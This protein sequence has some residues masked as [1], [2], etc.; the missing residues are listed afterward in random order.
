MRRT[1][2]LA[3]PMLVALGLSSVGADSAHAGNK[4]YNQRPFLAPGES[5]KVQRVISSGRAMQGNQAGVDAGGGSNNPN[6]S[7][8]NTGC[9]ELSVGN[10]RTSG[11]RGERVQD[12]IVVAREII[13]APINCGTRGRR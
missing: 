3:L 13:N 12:N 11:R 8:V 5:A 2:L 10:V 7:I 4:E 6:Q 1:S 9:G